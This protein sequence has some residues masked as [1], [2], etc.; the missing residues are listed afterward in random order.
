MVRARGGL[1]A[2]AATPHLAK[3]VLVADL[4]TAMVLETTPC[5]PGNELGSYT[6]YLRDSAS[7]PHSEPPLHTS[8]SLPTIHPA[9]K[10]S[11]RPSCLATNP[12]TSA[13]LKDTAFLLDTVLALPSNP[14][15]WELQKVQS[16][17]SWVE[18]RLS[19]SSL[20]PSHG[21]S[22][23]NTQDHF[24]QAIRMSSLFYCRAIH[25]RR[26][27]SEVVTEQDIAELVCPINHV[28]LDLWEVEDHRG[29]R[30]KTA[31]SNDVVNATKETNLY[32]LETLISLLAA[33]LPSAAKEKKDVEGIG[34]EETPMPTQESHVAR[35]MVVAG[36]VELALR[37]WEAV[38]RVLGRIVQLQ[39]WLSFGGKS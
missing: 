33:A 11:H 26:P 13:L 8:R 37:D 32:M 19:S 27:L 24:H 5:F 4:I 15:P 29:E 20:A 25:A 3:M 6:D 18:G 35:T 16:M 39:N 14:S 28:P 7:H 9:P 1:T 12:T 17:S 10:Q 22:H 21:G 30:H 2:L 23:H 31:G 34:G 36:V 38:V